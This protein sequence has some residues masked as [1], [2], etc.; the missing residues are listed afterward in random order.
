MKRFALLAFAL[1]S[2]CSNPWDSPL[3][4]PWQRDIEQ[5][6]P[7]RESDGKGLSRVAKME[8]KVIVLGRRE[9]IEQASDPL[10]FYSP[11]DLAVAWGKAGIEENRKQFQIRQPFRRYSWTYKGDIRSALE[12]EVVSMFKA[13]SANWHI[14]PA[15]RAVE[16]DLKKIK[17]GDT[18]FLRG[19]LVDVKSPITTIR[20][21]LVRDDQGD[22]A[23]EIFLV[24]E[25]RSF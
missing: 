22:G 6:N 17:R 15:S 3:P 1:F 2:A 21:S 25:I 20:T 24:E 7:L 16:L 23:C 19:F 4:S 14:I 9:Y 10:S 11:V 12:P 8:A 18:V 5:G 13:S